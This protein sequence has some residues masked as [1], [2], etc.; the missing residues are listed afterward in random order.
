MEHSPQ[1]H[2]PWFG[3]VT[4]GIIILL[5]GG[6]WIFVSRLIDTAEEQARDLARLEATAHKGEDIVRV[7]SGRRVDVHELTGAGSSSGA[8]GRVF[9]NRETGDGVLYMNTLPPADDQTEYRL[10]CVGM[11]NPV[12]AGSFVLDEHEIRNGAMKLFTLPMDD[13]T[14]R[15]WT[16]TLEPKGD[17]TTP[18]G[19]VLLISSPRRN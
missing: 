8:Y 12:P 3:Y 13:T 2:R 19:P 5:L 17:A 15:S 4:L 9:L 1:Q 16:L 10:W 6:L 11:G 14:Q 18:S 7:L